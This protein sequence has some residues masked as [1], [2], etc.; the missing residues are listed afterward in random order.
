MRI[1]QAGNW[2]GE[3]SERADPVQTTAQKTTRSQRT[4]A[5]SNLTA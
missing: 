5:T 1:D 4:V 2:S 3:S